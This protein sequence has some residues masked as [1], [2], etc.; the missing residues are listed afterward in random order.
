MANKS[1]D[2]ILRIRTE[3]KKATEDIKKINTQIKGIGDQSKK[4]G[5]EGKEAFHKMRV[6]TSGLRK[7]LGAI[8]NQLL[9]FTFVI[10]AVKKAL[11]FAVEA[12]NVARDGDEIQSKF[13]TVFKDLAESAQDWAVNFGKAVGRATQ[14]IKKWMSGLQDTFVPL[15]F[16]RKQSQGL[17]Q[18]LTKLAVDVASFNNKMDDEVIRDFTSA[19]VGNHE[20]VRKYGILITENSIK[21]EILNQGWEKSY[22]ELSELEKVQLRYNIILNST[23]DAQGDAIRTADSLAN[24][25][26]RKAAVQKNFMEYLG[27]KFIPISKAYNDILIKLYDNLVPIETETDKITKKIQG[28]K[29]SFNTLINRY[30]RL[31]NVTNKTKEEQKEYN[32]TIKELI[33]ISPEHLQILKDE[34]SSYKDIA[35]AIKETRE[36][37]KEYYKAQFVSAQ[38]ADLEKSYASAI[39]GG[40]NAAIALDEIGNS[41]TAHLQSQ[42]DSIKDINDVERIR[43][44]LNRDL[45]SMNISGE[46]YDLLKGILSGKWGE[47]ALQKQINMHTKKYADL[48]ELIN[49][50]K[51]DG[52]GEGGVS[53][54]LFDQKSLDKLDKEL[55]KIKEKLLQTQIDLKT[56]GLT[57]EFEKNKIKIEEELNLKLAAI[58]AELLKLE[59]K[60]AKS[61]ELTKEEEKAYNS[62]N[63]QKVKLTEIANNK[64]LALEKEKNLELK[65]EQQKSLQDLKDSQEEF[66]TSIIADKYEREL[67]ELKNHNKK[68]KDELAARYTSGTIWEHEYY[69]DLLEIQKGYLE[70]RTELLVNQWI[71][72][73]EFIH[74]IL[75]SLEAGYDEFWQ[76]LTDKDMTGS[77]RSN[78]IWKSMKESFISMLGDMI[79]QIIIAQ[80]IKLGLLGA[81]IA[82]A[83]TGSAAIALAWTPAAVA[84]NIATLGGAAGMASASHLAYLTTALAIAA[85]EKGLYIDK[86]QMVK[87]G[88]KG[89]KEVIVP[90]NRFWDFVS[91]QYKLP[92]GHGIEKIPIN[93]MKGTRSIPA[94]YAK[95]FSPA[96]NYR[97]THNVNNNFND[98]NIINALKQLIEINNGSFSELINKESLIQIIDKRPLIGNLSSRDKE[99]LFKVIKAGQ[100]TLEDS[101]T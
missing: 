83:A 43:L 26:K 42:I 28:Q 41:Y 47:L 95:T 25:E 20:T 40:F 39:Q 76:T 68:I 86:E 78:A 8:R 10:I 88:E 12:R 89:T 2:L 52:E 13:N 46:Q 15:G 80:A 91:G 77:E 22:N 63:E 32:K 58:D 36:E 57:R 85:A 19:L 56:A 4:A 29:A 66:E 55:D 44:G 45:M 64:I 73:H 81:E 51:K 5:Q 31:R 49:S 17:S 38:L 92:G 16:T 7:T 34:N 24:K 62:L 48:L 98:E 79:K 27:N 18:D 84:A 100:I 99:K 59:E 6:S 72:E 1:R 50:T 23:T 60:T 69:E 65:R 71:E 101:S 87:V 54:S 96:N 33:S 3:Q 21:Q 37:L 11:S 82:A 90:V 53:S 9:V 35:D 75:K 30:L 67:E 70:K 61:Q 94:A 97:A 93:P 14:D 74:N